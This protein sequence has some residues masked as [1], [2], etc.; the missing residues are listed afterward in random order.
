[1]DHVSIVQ[2]LVEPGVGP[3]HSINKG[4][5]CPWRGIRMCVMEAEFAV[6]FHDRTALPNVVLL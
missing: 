1:M 2:P 6:V 3:S 4:N 5:S